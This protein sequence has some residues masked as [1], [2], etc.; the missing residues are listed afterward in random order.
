MVQAI[1]ADA[2]R[3]KRRSGRGERLLAAIERYRS[4]LEKA[5]STMVNFDIW[6]PNIL[7]TRGTQGIEYA[8]IDPERSFWGDPIADF[9]CLEFMTSLAKKKVSLAAY[10]AVTDR[11]ITANQEETLRY[12][13]A[14]GYL[15]L[16]MKVERYY[17]YTPHHFGWWRNALTA[18]MLFKS[19]F[20][21]LENS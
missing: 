14:Q 8:W 4:V 10:N 3:Q 9:V 5:E 6:A 16:I 21:V 19:A 18:R 1:I 12:A 2:A 11:T 20:G 15:G 7:C 17:R 13:V